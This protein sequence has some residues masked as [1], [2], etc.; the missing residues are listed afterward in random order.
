MCKCMCMKHLHSL[1]VYAYAGRFNERMV[2]SL[3]SNPSCLLVDDEL[4]ILPTS[5]HVRNIEPLP[6]DGEAASDP[7]GKDT[8]LKGLSDSLADTLVG[9]CH[10]SKL[11]G[12][13]WVM[14]SGRTS[15]SFKAQ[16]PLHTVCCCIRCAS[17]VSA[18]MSINVLAWV[19]PMR[20]ME[21]P[22]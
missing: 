1:P 5:S 12:T 22:S 6:A 16:H 21:G 14:A 4:N 9:S 20:L 7:N 17:Y 10:S 8:D 19:E 11:P 2:L 15:A 3:A 18:V 13:M